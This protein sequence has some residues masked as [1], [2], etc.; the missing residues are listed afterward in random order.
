[1]TERICIGIGCEGTPNVVILDWPPNVDFWPSNAMGSMKMSMF[2]WA[3]VLFVE[4][5]L[6]VM[7]L[8][9]AVQERRTS[10]DLLRSLTAKRTLTSI[11]ARDS[12]NYFAMQVK[13]LF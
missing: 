7:V 8:I 6:F 1:M 5:I 12:A 11:M 10:G 3:A 9:K 2:T 4:C 13:F